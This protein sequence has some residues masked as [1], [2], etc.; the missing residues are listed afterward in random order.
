MAVHFCISS[1]RCIGRQRSYIAFC[2]HWNVQFDAKCV[3][4]AFIHLQPHGK[5]AFFTLNISFSR[6]F[7][8]IFTCINTLHTSGYKVTFISLVIYC[9]IC[10]IMC[11]VGAKCLAHFFGHFFLFCSFEILT[12]VN[13]V[14]IH[15]RTYCVIMILK[16]FDIFRVEQLQYLFGLCST[17]VLFYLCFQFC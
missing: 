16:W 13:V 7:R 15:T 11:S 12:I 4:H 17:I 3:C 5:I 10:E 6:I 8:H 2:T 14:D 1:T 9:T